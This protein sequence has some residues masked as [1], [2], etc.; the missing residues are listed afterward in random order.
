MKSALWVS[1]VT[2]TVKEMLWCYKTNHPRNWRQYG[3]TVPSMTFGVRPVHRSCPLNGGECNCD[4][5]SPGHQLFWPGL[6][7][8]ALEVVLAMGMGCTER[9]GSL[10]TPWQCLQGKL[11]LFV[12]L[13]VCLVYLFW[14]R[15]RA[16]EH[17]LGRGQREREGERESI[18]SRLCKVSKEPYRGLKLTNSEI[19]TWA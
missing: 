3:V 12:C 15:E 18:P 14:E 16:S 6:Y 1:E 8:I 19:M 4:G 10:W 2:M 7:G 17:E 9:P 11:F 5:V 13:F